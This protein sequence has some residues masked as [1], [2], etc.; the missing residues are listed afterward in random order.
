M[1]ESKGWAAVVK[2]RNTNQIKTLL[3]YNPSQ[4]HLL[5]NHAQCYRLVQIFLWCLILNPKYCENLNHPYYFE[6][7]F[8]VLY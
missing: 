1:I 6:K 4:D 7:Y 3:P 8:F 5:R 2:P